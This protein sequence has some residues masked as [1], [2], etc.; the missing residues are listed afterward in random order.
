MAA[1]K[2]F[3]RGDAIGPDVHRAGF[4]DAN[5]PY[6]APTGNSAAGLDEAMGSIDTLDDQG[7]PQI[8]VYP[9]VA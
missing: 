8:K 3:D 6:S 4:I 1:I 9:S 5:S 2:Q 7:Y